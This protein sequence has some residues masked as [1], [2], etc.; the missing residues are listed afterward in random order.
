[1]VEPE[2]VKQIH[3]HRSRRRQPECD[4][5]VVFAHARRAEEKDAPLPRAR[6]PSLSTTVARLLSVRVRSFAG[7]EPGW[8]AQ[9]PRGEKLPMCAPGVA[10]HALF[11]QAGQWN[12]GDL[13]ITVR[14]APSG[15][16]RGSA[17]GLRRK[18]RPAT[19]RVHC[20]P[21]GR[22]VS[23]PGVFETDR[24]VHQRC[25]R[26][27]YDGQIECGGLPRA[28]LDDQTL[29]VELHGFDM[30]A[31]DDCGLRNDRTAVCWSLGF[32]LVCGKTTAG[33]VRCWGTSFV[34]ARH[35]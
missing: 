28:W 19:R 8:A 20:R 13:T 24:C 2:F 17:G 34:S 25:L 1:M 16:V 14:R 35:R 12:A 32:D 21:D 7:G 22:A 5:E 30:V 31:H 4:R 15:A 33:D 23:P 3:G 27:T 6:R 10:S 9:R 18:L 29:D 11:P 26:S